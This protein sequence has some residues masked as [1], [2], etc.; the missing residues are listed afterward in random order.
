M[1][2]KPGLP[3]GA[4]KTAQNDKWFRL[5]RKGNG[6]VVQMLFKGKVTELGDW[7]LR[8]VAEN[9]VMNELIKSA[10]YEDARGID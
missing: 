2:K 5:K 10:S 3:N 8:F 4:L 9:K 6:W 1:T 7:D